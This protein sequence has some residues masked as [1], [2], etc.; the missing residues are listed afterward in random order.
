MAIATELR[1]VIAENRYRLRQRIDQAL[2]PTTA[3]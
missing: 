2:P 1:L 3:D